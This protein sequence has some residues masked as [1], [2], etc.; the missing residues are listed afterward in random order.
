MLPGPRTHPVLPGRVPHEARGHPGQ[1]VNPDTLSAAWPRF[2]RPS[3]PS[4][5]S[6]LVFASPLD[7]LTPDALLV[8]SSWLAQHAIICET[9]SSGHTSGRIPEVADAIRSFLAAGTVPRTGTCAAPSA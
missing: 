9:R 7:V 3:P 4:Q 1:P 8:D 2:C 5:G 6:I